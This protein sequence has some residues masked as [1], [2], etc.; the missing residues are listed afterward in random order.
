MKTKAYISF[1]LGALV[2]TMNVVFADNSNNS[3][4]S[5]GE[6]NSDSLA[7]APASQSDVIQQSA[8]N[9]SNSGNNKMSEIDNFF[10]ESSFSDFAKQ[11]TEKPFVIPKNKSNN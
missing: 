9:S 1:F 7:T 3:Q 8:D 5:L 11:P 2:I 4:Q 10:D 6:S